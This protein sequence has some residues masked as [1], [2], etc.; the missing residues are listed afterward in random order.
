MSEMVPSTLLGYLQGT[1]VTWNLVLNPG[2]DYNPISNMVP[3]FSE[4]EVLQFGADQYSSVISS[5]TQSGLTTHGSDFR[6]IGRE[7]V[8]PFTFALPGDNVEN[9]S[10]FQHYSVMKNEVD[11]PKHEAWIALGNFSLP[12][13]NR[14][15]TQAVMTN[16]T[17]LQHYS[18]FY[19]DPHLRIS[20][21]PLVEFRGVLIQE[22]IGSVVQALILADL[23]VTAEEPVYSGGQSGIDQS[24]ISVLGDGSRN[25]WSLFDNLFCKYV[26]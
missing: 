20:D 23:N 15:D 13:D 5:I 10:W 3:F 25:S 21:C 2:G 17:G 24:N 7:S 12:D 14:Q 4:A 6:T 9:G 16:V 11:I 22:L 1:N 8:A 26:L 18:Q 19:C